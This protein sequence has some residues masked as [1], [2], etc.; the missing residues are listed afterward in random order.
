MP[1]DLGRSREMIARRK[2]LRATQAWSPDHNDRSWQKFTRCELCGSRMCVNNYPDRRIRVPR[3]HGVVVCPW[4]IRKDRDTEFL[5]S[6]YILMN[7]LAEKEYKPEQ[8][9]AAAQKVLSRS[10]KA[11]AQRRRDERI[12]NQEGGS[13]TE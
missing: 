1:R 4:C 3:V 7:R 2:Q 11:R 6:M 5:V 10:P 13:N 9:R 12:K 8:V